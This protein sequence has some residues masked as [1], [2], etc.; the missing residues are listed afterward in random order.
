LLIKKYIEDILVFSLALIAFFISLNYVVNL[1]IAIGDLNIINAINAKLASDSGYPQLMYPTFIY[2]FYEKLFLISKFLGNE[3]GLEFTSRIINCTLFS[4]NGL[5]FYSLSKKYLQGK[6]PLLGLFL[7]YSSPSLFY[8]AVEIRPSGL[9]LLELMLITCLVENLVK[10]PDKKV[11]HLLAGIVSGLAI[12][13]KF[14][15]SYTFIY[16][17]GLL[18][19]YDKRPVRSS[20]I[21][22][23]LGLLLILPLAWP[24]IWNFGKY[25]FTPAVSNN[26]YFSV[27]PGLGKAVDETW[28]FP[29]G[30]YSLG[31]F[32]VLPIAAGVINTL[33][34]SIGLPLKLYSKKFLFIW[35][36]HI[37]IYLLILFNFTLYRLPHMFTLAVP[38]IILGATITIQFFYQGLKYKKIFAP[39]TSLILI[40]LIQG[41]VQADIASGYAKIVKKEIP[42]LLNKKPVVLLNNY[43]QSEI[44]GDQIDLFIKQN[45]PKTIITLD[46]FLFNYCKYRKNEVYI[47]HCQYFKNLLKGKEGYKS[48]VFRKINY[49][50]RDFF[51]I[52]SLSFKFYLLT[53]ID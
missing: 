51:I 41:S 48:Q 49:P 45:R 10:A 18:F 53:R 30:R 19:I 39:I 15:P 50:F 16:F 21:L 2:I 13:T 34:A 38:A 6:W 44:K 36:F 5:L 27:H 3:I 12:A 25:F 23:T 29:F 11:Y 46:S 17:F 47:R 37:P 43:N 9:L 28:S 4:I 42:E 7:F 33:I 31:L 52:D 35:V 14:N 40:S 26:Y 24:T 32:I 20:L 22:F 1:P 8:T